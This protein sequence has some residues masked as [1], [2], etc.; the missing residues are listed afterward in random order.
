MRISFF[1][2][3]CKVNQY[4]TECVAEQFK[5]SGY[6]IVPSGSD[7]DVFFINSCTVTSESD[8]KTRQ[9]LRKFRRMHPAA[10]MILAGCMPQ[11]FPH[12]VQVLTEADI[13]VGNTDP[14]DVPNLVDKFL[15]NGE[16]IVKIGSHCREEKFNTPSIERFE[17]HT[18]AF[19]KIQ[20]GCD[21]YCT[22]CIIPATRGGIRS[23]PIQEI[24][25]EA[26]QLADSGYSEVVLVGINLSSFGR[27]TGCNLCD[28]V[29]AVADVEKISRIRL[30]SLDPDLMNDEM[31]RRLAA[32]Q[33]FCPHFHLSLQSGCDET[34]KRMNRHYDSRF[35]YD[36]ITRIR[37]RFENPAITTDIMVGF[38]G[39]TEEEF[40]TSID[41]AKKV[42][43]AK[44]HVFAY[45]RRSGTVAAA[46]KNQV[47]NTIKEQRSRRMIEEMK[48]CEISFLN[49]NC[50]RIAEVLF[51][52][53]NNNI[54]FGYT[55]NYAPVRIE[56][57][58]N[59][60]CI[61]RSVELLKVKGE[62]IIGRL[63]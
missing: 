23:K 36:L 2:L 41:F 59:L 54:N 27:D 48:N 26:E 21:R 42:G 32:N 3:G 53:Q 31:L 20:D 60:C 9:M 57:D 7:T 52:T 10:V 37:A 39:E 58:E 16:R 45:S 15:A 33:K 12:D 29:D 4:E 24:K 14:A 46:L 62:S 49:S 40:E 56:S 18:R 63:I 25:L 6:S 28:A 61:T 55:K 51:E 8:R 1:T 11:A 5:K 19:M 30:G 50:G 44:C 34:L 38:A 13:V 47:T 17:D 22:Y 43:F 35:Y